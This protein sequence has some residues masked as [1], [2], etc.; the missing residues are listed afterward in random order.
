MP[1][2]V[3]HMPSQ[4]PPAVS[5]APHP[6]EATEEVKWST[7]PSNCPC[8]IMPSCSPTSGTILLE[9]CLCARPDQA[10]CSHLIAYIYRGTEIFTIIQNWFP[11]RFHFFYNGHGIPKVYQV[12]VNRLPSILLVSCSNVPVATW[13][14]GPI[15]SHFHRTG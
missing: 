11:L 5:S 9:P 3:P 6:P 2:M 12:V 4:P 1:Q 8:G 7:S 14:S 13:E 15:N 10:Y